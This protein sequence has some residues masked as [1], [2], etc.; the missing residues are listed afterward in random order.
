M[1]LYQVDAVGLQS[2]EAASDALEQRIGP[3]ILGVR[4]FRVAALREEI[5][6]AAA[7]CHGLSDQFF[8]LKVAFRRI[9]EVQP[10]VE[11]IAQDACHGVDGCLLKTD[12][13]SAETK[14]ADF[15]IRFAELSLFHL[16]SPWMEKTESPESCSGHKF[17]ES[18]PVNFRVAT[19]LD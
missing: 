2:R 4:A 16:S 7:R 1:K 17:G 15:H 3:P 8:A 10:G 18:R 14:R 5:E 13:G 19:I 11:R 6:L 9:D 12:F